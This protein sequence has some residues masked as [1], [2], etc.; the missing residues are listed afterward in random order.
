MSRTNADASTAVFPAGLTFRVEK[1]GAV[2]GNRGDVVIEGN[3]A[4]SVGPIKKVF[5]E[6]GSVRLNAAGITLGTIVADKG[7]VVLGGAIHAQHIRGRVVRFTEG[8]LKVKVIQAS[9]EAALLGSSIET[10]V[11]VAPK[12]GFGTDTS[13]RATAVDAGNDMGPHKVRGCF[14]LTEY[15]DMFPAGR[16]I[17][18]TYGITSGSAGGKEEAGNGESTGEEPADEEPDPET[19]ETG[20]VDTSS[21]PALVAELVQSVSGEP[22]DGAPEPEGF[23]PI[24]VQVKDS[25]R[26]IISSYPKEEVPPP[27][28]FLERL[29]Q[30]DRFDY[31]KLQ[32]NTIWRDL[33]KY[34]QKKGLRITT[35]VTQQFQAIQ[36]LVKKLPA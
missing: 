29:V 2:I 31:I 8:S 21:G 1:D 10:D 30:E 18:E 15:I 27:V 22:V 32:L 3:L 28:V 34:H 33:L 24:E 12:V 5:S 36:V 17:L 11:V 19:V 23:E 25:L 6:E 26:R 35:G 9:E 20:P 14:S 13:G 4:E 16:K 7:E